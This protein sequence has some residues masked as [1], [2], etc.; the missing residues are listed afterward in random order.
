MIYKD[1]KREKMSF[2]SYLVVLIIFIDRRI[3]DEHDDMVMQP[4][5]QQH[6]QF[7]QAKAPRYLLYDVNPGEGFN[8][9]RDVYMRIAHLV[10]V[11]ND[12]AP[13]ILVLPSWSGLFHWKSRHVEQRKLPWS[14]FFDL[15]SLR[16]FVPVIEFEDFLRVLDKPV[17]EE[18]YYLQNYKEGWGGEWTEKMDFREC[19]DP[20][21]YEQI[22]EGPYYGWFFGY[23]DAVMALK[24]QCLSIQGHASSLKPFLLKNTTAR[25]VM[26]DRA[27]TVVHDHFGDAVF[28]KARRSMVFA[29]HLRDLGDQ[30]RKEFLNSTDETDNTIL[31]EDWTKMKRNHGDAK[32]GPY[33]GV[34]LRRAD[35]AHSR[36]KDVPTMKQAA[37]NITQLLKKYSLTKVFI[38]TDTHS[39]E[40]DELKGYLSSYEVYRY[41]PTP[42]ILEKY[43]DGGV[44]II[45]QWIC[46]HARHFIGTRESTFSF[47]IQ[48]EREILGF[49]P[50]TTFNTFC[51]P[52]DIKCEQPSRWL[53]VY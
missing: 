34:H 18:V 24:F 4:T 10:R 1:I 9:R 2:I 27:E 42:E 19:N 25:S 36:K 32:G 12:D 39:A 41:S 3:C 43:K 51:G 46:A 14:L 21:A 22:D 37:R 17:V 7:G 13:W 52:D 20:P 15:P 44:A 8:L 16:L 45:D 29:K 50:D 47:R 38:A 40:F 35:F 6:T 53:I 49:D 31:E 28:W 33:I 26:I 30:F 23:G 5:S 48:D 11:L